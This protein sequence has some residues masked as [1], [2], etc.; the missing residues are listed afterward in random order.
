MTSPA[1][2][3]TFNEEGVLSWKNPHVL[4]PGWYIQ[5]VFP[6]GTIAPWDG[7]VAMGDETSKDLSN[8]IYGG[9]FVRMF[10]L[11]ADANLMY[12][13][14]ISANCSIPRVPPQPPPP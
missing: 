14:T 5:L 8:A 1:P 13:P 7:F 11:D 12:T 4:P 2:E 9:L 6:D 10:A 3:G